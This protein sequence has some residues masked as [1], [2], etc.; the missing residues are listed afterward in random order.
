METEVTREIELP[1]REAWEAGLVGALECAERFV[2]HYDINKTVLTLD[3]SSR[4]DGVPTLEEVKLSIALLVAKR[5]LVEAQA[6]LVHNSMAVARARKFL[7]SHPMIPAVEKQKV[8]E[9]LSMKEGL[10][11]RIAN[12]WRIMEMGLKAWQQ[13]DYWK[14]R[15]PWKEAR[16]LFLAIQGL[17]EVRKEDGERQEEQRGGPGRDEPEARDQ[18]GGG[19]QGDQGQA[20]G[21]EEVRDEPGGGA[22]PEG[23][24]R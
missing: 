20:H 5:M 14:N 21:Q 17:Q 10:G 4:K 7:M 1:P 16:K 8:V 19:H 9:A 18:A 2:A 12:G 23:A 3:P 22:H 11:L 15:E 24:G 13:S 6:D